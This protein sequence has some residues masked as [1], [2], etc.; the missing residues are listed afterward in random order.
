M[1]QS[2]S[3]ATIL[4]TGGGGFIGQALIRHFMA[5]DW[6]TIG[7]GL[8]RPANFPASAQWREYDLAQTSLP[9]ELFVGVDVLVHG[10]LVKRDVERNVAAGRLLLQ[11][12]RQEGVERIV[13]LSSLAAHATALSSYGK[14]K[15]ALERLFEAC[16]ALAVRPGLVI[17]DGGTFG[18]T[19]AYLRGQRFVPLVDGGTQPL[20]TVHV[21]DLV[22]AV[23]AAVACDVRGTFTIAERDAI[24]YRAFYQALCAQLGVNVTFVPVP[25][26]IADLAVRSAEALRIGLPIDRDNLLG[27]RAMRIDA[28]P[29]LDLPEGPVRDYRASIQ[30]LT[31]AVSHLPPG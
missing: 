31:T 10:A 20:Q 3:P 1:T 9:A 14:Q 8:H 19:C 4:V 22:A 23:Y 16:G 11:R 30:T 28:G 6:R 13:F 12:A 18:A 7:C 5:R 21:D 26:W 27:L 2:A 25:F 15:F 17:G 24:S 29:R